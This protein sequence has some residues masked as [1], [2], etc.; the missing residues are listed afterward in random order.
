MTDP[1][2]NPMFKLFELQPKH[3]LALA[4]GIPLSFVAMVKIPIWMGLPALTSSDEITRYVIIPAIFIGILAWVISIVNLILYTVKTAS[5]HYKNC[6]IREA[7][8]NRALMYLTDDTGLTLVE[9]GLLLTQKEKGTRIFQASN[10]GP[11]DD[12]N[13]KGIVKYKKYINGTI[14]E[15]E[16][17]LFIWDHPQLAL[18]PNKDDL[19]KFYKNWAKETKMGGYI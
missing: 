19:I 8:E 7:E 13:H 3:I 16:V 2:T 12:L 10:I 4:V 9:V 11:A 1:V 5:K 18:F 15:Y 17:P 14:S 6:K